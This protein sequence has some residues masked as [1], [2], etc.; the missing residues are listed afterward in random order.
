[1]IR[2]LFLLILF[3]ACSYSLF[4]QSS[5]Y[6]RMET[7]ID[8][9]VHDSAFSYT[10]TFDTRDYSDDYTLSPNK[11]PYYYI[12]G[13]DVFFKLTLTRSLDLFIWR[14]NHFVDYV[15]IHLLDASG[16]EVDWIDLNNADF[17]IALLPGTYYIV[18]E[19]ANAKSNKV[20]HEGPV[21]LTITGEERA[22]GEDFYYPMDL[23]SFGSEFTVSHRDDVSH[24]ESD[25]EPGVGPWDDYHDMVHR[26]TLSHPVQLKLEN[27]LEGAHTQLKRWEDDVVEPIYTVSNNLLYYEL[28]P[29][30]YYI[31]TWALGWGYLWQTLT[32]TGN[33]MP[34]GNSFSSPIDIVGEYYG[35]AF[36]YDH[37]F[38]TS[39]FKY[40]KEPEKAGNEVYYR[41]TFTEPMGLDICNCESEV[42]DTY[43]KVYSSN[44]ELMYSNDDT[45]G[46]GACENGEH[47]YLQIPYLSPGTYY[48]VVDGSTNGNINLFIN[49]A[50]SGPIGDEF[51]TAIDAGTHAGGFLF[52]DT[53]D[54]SGYTDYTGHTSFPGKPG[55]DVFY[56]FTLTA[57]LDLTISHCGSVLTDTYLSLLDA[58]GETLYSNDSYTGEEQ[59]RSP[60]N[61]L[62]KVDNLPAGTYYV[63]SEGNIENGFVTINIEGTVSSQDSLS[64][65]ST[66]PYVLSYVPTVATDDV[67]S[68]ADAEVRHEIQ[69]YDHFGNPTVKVQHGFSP[70]GHDLITLQDYDALNRTSKLWLPVAYGSS[71]GSYPD[72]GKLKQSVRSFYSEDSHP[73]SLTVYDGSALNEVVEEYGP[74]KSWHT[75]GHSV[76][77]DRMTNSSRSVRI[78]Q[79]ET[80][81]NLRV[82]GTYAEQTLDAVRTTDEDG[83]VTYEFKD[84]TGRVLLSRQMNGDEAHD[85]YTVYDDYGN[86]CFVLPPLA[87]DGLTEVGV[88]DARSAVLQSYAYIY[89]YDKYNRCIYKK[90][91]GCDPVYTVYDAADRPIFTQDGELRKRNE[92][93]FSIPDVFGR[94]VLSGICKNQPAYGA[95]STPLDS[96]VV[97]AVWANEDNALKGYRLEGVTL[98][99]PTVL[100]ASY[101]DTYDFLGKNGIPDDATTAYSETSGYGQRYGD[102]CKGQQTGSWTARFTGRKCTGFI[103][104]AL[105]YDDRY[106]VI[107]RQGN[108]E[109]D[110][111]ESVYTA[112]NFEGSPTQEKHVHS[113]PGQAPVTEVHTY[114]YDL[115]NRLLT[116]VYQL[117]D[118]DPVT[119]VDNAY[120]EVGRLL[121]NKRNGVS[122]LRTNYS[123]NLRS[124]LK[125]VSSPLFSQTLNYQETIHDIAP[126]YNGNI[127]SLFWRTAQHDA[128]TASILVSSP[129]KGYRFTYDGLSRLKDAV[130]GEG[131]TLNQNRNR[132]NEQITGYDKMGNILGLLRY[133]QTGTDSYGL[134]DNLNLT[135]HG[136]QLESVY[137]NATNS[138]FG[139]GME[140]KDNASETVE[141]A[142]DKNGNLTKDLNKNISEIQY[143][144]LNLPSHIS[145]ADGSSIEYE[146][147]ADGRKVRTTHIINNDTTTT[148]Y[149]GNAIYE[150]GSLTMLLNEAGYYSFQDKKFHF[151]IKDHQGNV[152]VVAD[153]TGQ[154]DEVNDYYPFGGLMSNGC[155]NVQPYKY[156]GKELD[157]KNE[158]DWYDYGARHYDAMIG[159]WH[160]VDPMAEKYYGWSPCT[161]CLAN[162]IK[163]VDIIGAFTSPYYTE[164]GQFLGVDENGF[165][166][167]I[168]I[169]DEEVF[170]KYSKNGI[171]NS[172]D[173]QKDM[174]T[175][176]MKDKLLTSAAESHIYTDI[177]KKSTDAKLDV[178]QLYNGEVSIVEDVV[179]RKDEVVGVGYNNPEGHRNAPKYSQ[180]YVDGKIR[181][182]VA[183]GSNQ[184]DLYTV[185][186]VQNYLGVHEYYGH[187]INNWSQKD[188]HWKCYNAQMNHPTF[189]KLPKDQQY[190]IKTRKYHYYINRNR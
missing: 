95:E 134:I 118:E 9:G 114:T 121:V 18:A 6:H 184:H 60:E 180:S 142:Y 128:N 145:F 94:V 147:A 96:V 109:Q 169:T 70:L 98:S 106:R 17:S 183:Q 182:T 116:S 53:R 77:N 59:C 66:Q 103:Y 159:R 107:Q 84:K 133:G 141:Y 24:Y 151:Y 137:D 171:A 56:K 61:A 16:N 76:K 45:Y 38:D 79:A 41:I 105:Y 73:Y 164:D 46:R 64:L 55:N 48:I 179:K 35:T 153:E 125:G 119:L 124:W 93:S 33:P 34:V 135:Y 54:T 127:S 181:V 90:L 15:F 129:E 67:L 162:P 26:F 80:D 165:T 21:S 155:N 12:F 86:V 31:H 146:Y 19:T 88:Y 104:S 13:N 28:D 102:D 120:D 3:A 175:I 49:G 68:L 190:E 4:G 173:I 50:L 58:D 174:N 170:E 30:T 149:C 188:T 112:Y 156:N 74:G 172:K 85:T 27:S 42:R 136:N 29:G 177:L 92:W 167:N 187:G 57:P 130:Y 185:E 78:Y 140:F 99:S 1:M 8:L 176:L 161:Y 138:V 39:V 40:S 163:Y 117:D 123:Y 82:A 144:I 10:K 89:R 52:T 63:I 157:R 11:V 81:D 178:S 150:N 126:C 166:G 72:L 186:S 25:Y 100:S 47:A 75:T 139:N 65:T 71:D 2:K 154:V 37:T 132:F 122:E 87:A 14:N 97:K 160:V 111:T 32:L 108:N 44:L 189:S 115:A 143:N 152:R 36:Y 23:G 5:Y 20:V 101:Y 131:I 158:L 113:V 43:L 168:Y 62:I 110:G 22:A 69:Y 7:A 91:P 83:N 148:V 51:D